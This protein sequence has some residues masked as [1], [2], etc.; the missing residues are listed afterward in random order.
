ML[1][2]VAKSLVDDYLTLIDDSSVAILPHL[3]RVAVEIGVC[4][5]VADRQVHVSE[6]AAAIQVAPDFLY[7]ILRA[8]SSLGV[9]TEPSPRCFALTETGERLRSDADNSLRDS[10]MNVDSLQAWLYAT[11]AIRSGGTAF[12]YAHHNDFFGQKDRNPEANRLFLRRMRERARRCYGQ[13]ASAIDWGPSNVVMDIGGGDG[14]L[15]EQ[16]LCHARHL[17][18]VLFDRP[19]AISMVAESGHLGHLDGRSHLV[20]GDFFTELPHGADVH[21]MCSILH[22]WTDSAAATILRN[23]REVLRP[24]G[25]LF[26]VEMVVPGGDEWH[27]SKLSDIGMMVLTGGRERTEDEF[28]KLLASAGYS[29]S[30]ARRIPGSH[31]SLLEAA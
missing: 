9:L 20:A 13:V 10:L 29:L 27:P 21:L 7:R 31:F 2:G 26:I 6:L 16:I 23:S 5:A 8:L 25:R 15:L 3:L 22:D 30:S 24:T 4:D 18:G 19:S 11:E 1:D 14:Y 28:G 12:E 17:S